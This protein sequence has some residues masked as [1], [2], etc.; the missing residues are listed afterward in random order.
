MYFTDTMKNI[1]SIHLK[2][3][4]LKK[5]KSYDYGIIYKGQTCGWSPSTCGSKAQA[6]LRQEQRL[7]H[8]KQQK[9]HFHSGTDVTL[10]RNYITTSHPPRY[11]SLIKPSSVNKASGPAPFGGIDYHRKCLTD[12]HYALTHRSQTKEKCQMRKQH[13]LLL[14]LYEEAFVII[15]R[16]IFKIPRQHWFEFVK[17][18]FA[19]R[20]DVQTDWKQVLFNQEYDPD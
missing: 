5:H 8:R 19:V 3:S 6:P 17:N 1:T 14:R 9:H 10:S 2:S 20:R 4:L 18:T 13:C 16:L 11:C 7:W 15:K 12:N